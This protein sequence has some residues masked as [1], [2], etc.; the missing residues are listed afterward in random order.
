MS[1]VDTHDRDA[2]KSPQKSDR[3]IWASR[4]CVC[5]SVLLCRVSAACRRTPLFRILMIFY[6]NA[7]VFVNDFLLIGEM[8][9]RRNRS[10]Q[11]DGWLHICSQCVHA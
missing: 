8:K 4:V 7:F 2:H 10:P 9:S 5:V 11:C 6:L 3:N 1:V